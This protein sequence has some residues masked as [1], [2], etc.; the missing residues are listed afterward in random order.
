SVMASYLIVRRIVRRFPFLNPGFSYE[1]NELFE[2]IQEIEPVF[3][4]IE[5]AD[6]KRDFLEQVKRHVEEWPDIFVKLFPFY[7]SRY[8]VDELE[9]SENEERLRALFAQITDQYREYREAFVWMAKNLDHA[10]LEKYKLDYE[11]MLIG[12]IHLLDITT[13]EITNRRDV[14]ENRKLNKQVQTFLFKENRL[15]ESVLKADEDS[16]ARLFTLVEDVK[17]LDPSISIGLKHKIMDKYPD[18]KFYGEKEAERVRGGLYVTAGSY[19]RKQ[20]ELS[21]LLEVEVP[22]NSKEIGAAIQLGDLSENAE[23]KAAKERQELLSTTVAKLKE[24]IDRAQIFD[25]GMIDSSKVSFGTVVK[26]TNKN[27]SE[28]EEFTILGPWES[29]PSRNIVS[30]LS[31]FVSKLWNH[32]AGEAVSF[33]INDRE[34]NYEVMEIAPAKL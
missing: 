22:D 31:P 6:L 9:E 27:T 2:Q 19:E 24:E 32:K 29:D 8:I 30:Y 5:D 28:I 17:D 23:Y 34:Y 4:A 20:Q 18:F 3:R 16:I 1:F 12:L 14:S 10:T 11:K 21:H 26:L 25:T 33:V 13:R 15:E 7:L